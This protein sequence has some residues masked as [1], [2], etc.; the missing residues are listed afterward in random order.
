MV[1]LQIGSPE[2]MKLHVLVLSS[3]YATS[4]LGREMTMNLARHM[5]EGR[6]IQEPPIMKILNNTVFHFL[7]ILEDFEK[8]Y[9][10]FLRE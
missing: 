9:M 7:P 2:E 6:K 5:I 1:L 3:L 10:Q 8:V 4:P